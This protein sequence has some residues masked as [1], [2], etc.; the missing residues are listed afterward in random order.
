MRSVPALARRL[1]RR[2]PLVAAVALLAQ[3]V[4]PAMPLSAQDAGPP[5]GP[6][7]VRPA[8]PAGADTNDALA[9]LGAA[10]QLLDRQP[11]KAIAYFRWAAALDPQSPDPLYGERVALLLGNRD[12]LVAYMQGDAKTRESPEMRRADSLQTL[13]LMRAPL[14]YRRYDRLL[15]TAYMDAWVRRT[16]RRSGMDSESESEMQHEVMFWLN[17]GNAPPYLRAWLA[18]SDGDFAKSVKL[19]GEAI[20][21]ARKHERGGLLAEKA[22]AFAHMGRTDSAIANFRAS[23]SAERA[24]DEDRLVF[25]LESRAQMEHVLGALLES[26]GDTAAAR[27]AYARSVTE[28]LAYYPAHAALGAQA[29]ERGDTATA[30]HELREAVQIAGD[31]PGLRFTRGLALATTGHVGEGATELLKATQLAPHWAEPHLLLARLHDA[32]ELR[33]E[34]VMHWQNFAARAARAH[35]AR[36]MADRRLAPV[37]AQGS[38]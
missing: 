23:M 28:D 2:T 22:R 38:R 18:Y 34:A 25:A 6:P 5:T 10:G 33:E 17:S 11:Q 1:L 16:A 29:Y 31:E 21:R 8:L 24:R 12:R 19:Y 13:A 20:G 4:A 9:Y 3:S 15:L 35:P 26:A 27:E 7:T 32:A 37:A 14:F 36:S 30:L